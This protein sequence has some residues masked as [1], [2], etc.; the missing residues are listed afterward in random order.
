MSTKPDSDPYVCFRRRELKPLRKFRRSDAQSL[1]RLQSLRA[2][3]IKAKD[4]LL[5]VASRENIRKEALALDVAIFEQRCVVRRLKKKL[6]LPSSDRDWDTSS[7]VKPRK[8]LKKLMD[9]SRCVF[10]SGL[11]KQD[12]EATKIRIPIHKIRDAA[13][14]VT[15]LSGPGPSLLLSLEEKVKKRKLTEEKDGWADVTE[16]H[17][18]CNWLIYRIRIW[19]KQ[20]VPLLGLDWSLWYQNPRIYKDINIIDLVTVK[21]VSVEAVA[22]FWIDTC[23]DRFAWRKLWL[24]MSKLWKNKKKGNCNWNDIGLMKVLTNWILKKRF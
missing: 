22:W 7:M 2:E 20:H 24:I 12:R 9:S 6:G 4:I 13:N 1:E 14:L 3:L 8:R 5:L 18:F 23:Q 10:F 15:D 17:T 11:L 16:V 19:V 21:G